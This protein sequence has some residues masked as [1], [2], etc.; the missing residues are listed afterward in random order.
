M[1]FILWWSNSFFIGIGFLCL[2]GPIEEGPYVLC[3]ELQHFWLTSFWSQINVFGSCQQ[4][5]RW[6]QQRKE[7]LPWQQY[8]LHMIM[9][10]PM[11]LLIFVAAPGWM[12]KWYAIWY[13][14]TPGWPFLARKSTALCIELY[15]A[16]FIGSF[17]FT[18]FTA[19]VAKEHVACHLH[20]QM[21]FCCLF[22][23]NSC[24][25]VTGLICQCSFPFM[26]V[27]LYLMS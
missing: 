27:C 3:M 12:Q 7:D 20:F 21:H 11:Y 14:C 1:V 18:R 23:R 19:S 22:F 6:L 2:P 8:I 16:L 13:G 26:L 24:A 10:R 4:V 17:L 25:L 9:E 5:M 15:D